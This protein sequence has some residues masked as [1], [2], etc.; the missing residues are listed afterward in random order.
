MQKLLNI[1]YHHSTRHISA[2]DNSPLN[3]FF[4]I[5]II[6]LSQ[7]SLKN[8]LER[9]GKYANCIATEYFHKNEKIYYDRTDTLGLWNTSIPAEHI[10]C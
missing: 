1:T 7:T 10:T 9:N 3:V 2:K 5:G 6:T 4:P 8:I